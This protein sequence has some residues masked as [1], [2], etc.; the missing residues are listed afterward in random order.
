[1]CGHSAIISWWQMAQC[2]NDS[3]NTRS[4]AKNFQVDIKIPNVIK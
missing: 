3:A 2:A 4:W 1:M